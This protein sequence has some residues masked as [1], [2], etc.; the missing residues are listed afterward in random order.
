MLCDFD[1]SLAP[2]L[3]RIGVTPFSANPMNSPLINLAL[4]H[5]SWPQ[6]RTI[7]GSHVDDEDGFESLFK[8]CG[9]PNVIL[10]QTHAGRLRETLLLFDKCLLADHVQAPFLAQTALVDFI[11]FID[12]ENSPV[13]GVTE[14]QSTDTREYDCILN[15]RDSLRRDELTLR[16]DMGFMLCH[17]V[18]E[19]LL[20]P[21][22]EAL[23]D[24][25]LSLSPYTNLSLLKLINRFTK[26][27]TTHL[28][29]N[30]EALK[31]AAAANEE[32]QLRDVISDVIAMP[33]GLSPSRF[34]LINDSYTQRFSA[35][36]LIVGGN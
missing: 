36:Q 2:W 13:P 1:K 3:H 14:I 8:T 10:A 26:N 34:R 32:V 30:I 25:A 6:A 11:E 19:Y 27:K 23:C 29:L 4:E 12:T 24:V 18:V 17:S 33:M 15:D 22:E 5:Y 31:D 20:W 9:V 35:N 28:P 21:T 16:R 7:I